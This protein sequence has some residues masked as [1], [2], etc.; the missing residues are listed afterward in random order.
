MVLEYELTVSPQNGREEDVVAS[1]EYHS[2]RPDT[3]KFEV[4]NERSI[5]TTFEMIVTASC[6]NCL[7]TKA[8]KIIR[9]VIQNT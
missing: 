2:G 7:N 9:K 4:L 8:Y 1:L 6:K 5:G 3:L